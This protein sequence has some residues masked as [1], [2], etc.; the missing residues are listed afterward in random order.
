ME[1][2]HE[3]MAGRALG[4]IS[5]DQDVFIAGCSQAPR[6]SHA[7]LQWVHRPGPQHLGLQAGV[8]HKVSGARG[9][10]HSVLK[11]KALFFLGGK[12]VCL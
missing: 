11:V 5:S 2:G 10:Q 7:I 9:Y 12:A 6:W 3:Q 1:L 4:Q 8:G